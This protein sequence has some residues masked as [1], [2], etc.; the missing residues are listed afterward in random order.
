M[1]YF[2]YGATMSLTAEK[3]KNPT[4]KD[5]ARKAKVSV[6]AVSQ[7]LNN[8]EANFCSEAKKELVKHIARELHYQPNFGY[9]VM[10]G[11]KTNTV[12]IVFASDRTKNQG[13]ITRLAMALAS[14]FEDKG[15][16]VYMATMGELAK[17]NFQ[18]VLN[19][20]NRGCSSFILI[21]TP[22]GSKE[23][24]NYFDEYEINYIGYNAAQLRRNIYVDSSY[25]VQAF[26]EKF[27][28]EGRHNFKLMLPDENLGAGRLPGLFRS[29]PKENKDELISKYCVI[30]SSTEYETLLVETYQEGYDQTKKIIEID[31]SIDG[32]IYLSDYYALGGAKYLFENDY[33]IGETIAICGYNNTQAVRFFSHPISTADHNIKNLCE[34]LIKNINSKCPINK[35]YKPEIIFK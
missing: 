9:R 8:R 32:I 35:K 15:F 11:M 25:A 19:L 33:K 20:V 21:G 6:S 17:E 3:I 12:G 10:T 7:I 5:I 28:S 29:F 26:I 34:K 30:I 16:S 14:K 27:I 13:H 2:I 23:I 24:E 18:K 4:L 22:F 31:N 1:N